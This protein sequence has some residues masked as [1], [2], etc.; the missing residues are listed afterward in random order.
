M[1]NTNIEVKVFQLGDIP[2]LLGV[3]EKLN[4]V[5]IV[6]KYLPV[7]H[8]HQG[9]SNG[10]LTAIWLCHIMSTSNHAK[11]HVREWS[12][13][14]R[15]TLE[16]CCRQ[17]IRDVDFDDS[18]LSLLL[19]RLHVDT[20]KAGLEKDLFA[21][22]VYLYELETI[23]EQSEK[24]R[25]DAPLTAV[26][27][28]TT[29]SYGYHCNAEGVMQLGH[30][31]DHRSD[32]LQLKLLAAAV[33]GK[34]LHHQTYPGNYADD[35]L[36]YPAIQEVRKI[37]DK[38][39][40]LYVGDCK[41]AAIETRAQIIRDGD[42]YLTHLP[43][44]KGNKEFI[45]QCI[46][47]IVTATTQ[48]VH[49]VY[50]DDVLLGGGNEFSRNLSYSFDEQTPAIEWNET[51]FVFHSNSH[52]AT[53]QKNLEKHLQQAIDEI[54]KL[55][56]PVAKGKR[57]IT[58]ENQLLQNIATICQR[59]GVENMI[60]VEYKQESQTQTKYVGK[61]RGS[62]NRPTQEVTKIR[63]QIISATVKEQ[64]VKE[65]L[66]RKGW[67]AYVSNIPPSVINLDNA[68][69]TY[70]Q[71]Y[72]LENNFHILKDKPLSIR[73]LYV[74]HDH[75][76]TGLTNLLMLSFRII[77]YI[78]SIIAEQIL[79]QNKPLKGLYESQSPKLFYTATC[80]TIL[81]FFSKYNISLCIVHAEGQTI[82]LKI[83]NMKD[84][85]YTILKMLNIS[86]DKYNNPMKL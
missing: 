77:D 80:V 14:H 5:S 84:E 57:Q 47:T 61:G 10:W 15:D 56:P 38:K 16:L 51:V 12:I 85:H 52:F 54:N 69:L 2:L 8:L 55:T 72:H 34:L 7:H 49:L 74:H 64:E 35:K 43:E 82:Q 39:G 45:A 11:C 41:M 59:H 26:H 28:D 71:N 60:A 17:K 67:T 83:N 58:E 40:M 44:T 70:R 37:I 78:E 76:I 21:E 31:K 62:E 81:K 63:Y 4:I 42:F 27:I 66:R 18:R 1:E 75:Q 73:P 46:E 48:P 3:I 32:L 22:N 79:K 68:I 25:S 86:I 65:H 23:A 33:K 29:T 20:V 9:L 53:I 50:R 13:V 24:I 36:Y 6:D 19:A 30:S